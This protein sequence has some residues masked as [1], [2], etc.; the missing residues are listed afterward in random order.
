MSHAAQW[1]GGAEVVLEQLI[2]AATK[3]GFDAEL[4]APPGG[5]V[6]RLEGRCSRVYL[7]PIVPLRRTS[8]PLTILS[9]LLGW[10]WGAVQLARVFRRSGPALIHANSGAAALA[11]CVSAAVLR[12]PLVWHQHDIV[13]DRVVNRMVLAPAALM[14]ARVVVC[15][16]AVGGSLIRLGVRKRRVVVMHNRVRDSFFAP[17]PP[18]DR[19][20]SE[21]GLPPSGRIVAMAGRLVPYKAHRVFLD[22]IA[23]LTA[24][25]PGV[26]GVIAGG[27]P[28]LGPYDVDPFPDYEPEIAQRAMQPDLDGRI[29][30]LGHRDDLRTVLA[31]AD[32]LVQSA[33]NEPFPLVV[34]EALASAVPVI[35]SASGGH[36]EAIVS[37]ETG[38]LVPVGDPAALALAISTL[39]DDDAYRSAIGEAGQAYAR[40]HFAESGLV[41]ELA[42]LYESILRERR[43]SERDLEQCHR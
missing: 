18:R 39:L 5:L 20:R 41:I 6:A 1:G 42:Q 14:C 2:E 11:C 13:P 38:L 37:G 15:S 35:A 17:L 31:S 36:L 27:K 12:R 16:R 8:N 29:V 4:A 25:R 22:A 43:S 7:L 3:A 9:L 30:F 33:V 40:E 24:E 28:T 19:A 21:L 10:L 23:L 26:L 32:V 34:L